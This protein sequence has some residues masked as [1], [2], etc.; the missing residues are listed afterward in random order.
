MR[1]FSP[2]WALEA[3]RN[4][5]FV[6]GI[7]SDAPAPDESTL[8]GKIGQTFRDKNEYNEII[9]HGDLDGSLKP[10]LVVP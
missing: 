1:T 4:L 7:L 5:I 6:L 2:P 9:R 10:W 3:A 8:A